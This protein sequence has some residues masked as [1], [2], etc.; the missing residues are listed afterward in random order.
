MSLS[1]SVT[2]LACCAYLDTVTMRH[3]IVLSALTLPSLLNSIVGFFTDGTTIYQ[4]PPPASPAK[5]VDNKT[6]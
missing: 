5:Q 1:Q 6:Q 2:V 3:V 4:V